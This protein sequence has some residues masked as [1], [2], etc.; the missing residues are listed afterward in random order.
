MSN[1]SNII[2][3]ILNDKIYIKVGFM[4][5]LTKK[6]NSSVSVYNFRT[7]IYLGGLYKL[8]WWNFL[9]IV[10]ITLFY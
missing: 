4:W 9:S 6:N 3:E 5:G 10:A 8:L 2:N 7:I 1:N